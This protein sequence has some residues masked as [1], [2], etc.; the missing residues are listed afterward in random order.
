ME[1]IAAIAL[2]TFGGLLVKA[3]QVNKIDVFGA[4]KIPSPSVVVPTTDVDRPPKKVVPGDAD[5][6]A[7]LDPNIIDAEEG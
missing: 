5:F 7:S 4:G 2:M 6:A 3:V 1:P